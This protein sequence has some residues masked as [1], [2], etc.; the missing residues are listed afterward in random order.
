MFAPV[1]YCG[2]S[3]G[4]PK[5]NEAASAKYTVVYYGNNS[6]HKLEVSS[7]TY[8]CESHK[9]SAGL[10]IPVDSVLIMTYECVL[11]AAPL[12]TAFCFLVLII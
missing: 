8:V 11:R 10:L 9:H 1:N 2:A 5:G 12:D 7:C 3:V 4:I 6:F